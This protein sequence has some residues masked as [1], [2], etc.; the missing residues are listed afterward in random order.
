MTEPI[1]EQ[2]VS[3]TRHI[4]KLLRGQVKAGRIDTEYMLRQFDKIEDL[5]ARI[6]ESTTQEKH[7][8]RFEALYLVGR[9]LGTSL[10]EQ[11]VLDQVMD[12][13]IQ[14]T[15][16]ERGFLMLRDDDGELQPKVARNLDQQTLGSDHFRYSRTIANL[17]LDSGEAIL[18]TNAA[19]DSRFA[20]QVS[21]ISQALR[22]IMAVP[23]WARGNIMGIAYVEN[24]IVAGLFSEDDLNTLEA[25]AGQAAIAIDNAILFSE[26]DEQLAARVEELRQL[27]RVDM[28]LNETL[29]PDEAMLITLESACRIAGAS[30]GHLGIL[31]QGEQ[32]CIIAEH[33]YGQ[34]DHNPNQIL[35]LGGTYPPIWEVIK[36]RQPLSFQ[37]DAK[38]PLTLLAVPVLRKEEVIGLMVLR[39]ETGG[40]STNEQE[41]V[42]RVVTRAAVTIENAR[43][44]AAVQSADKAKSEFVGIVA[45]DL[46]TP[47]TSI[48]GYADLLRMHS[49]NLSKRQYEFANRITDTVKRMEMLVSDL[50]D[51][52]RIESGQFLM[53][54]TRVLVNDVVTAVRDTTMPQI[55]ERKHKYIEEIEPNLPVLWTDYYRL[56]QVL[57]NLISNA[58]KYTPDGG[59]VM[60]RAKREGERVRF[61]V[62]DTGIG[63]SEEGLR[64][65]GTK[66]WRS[67]DEY[68]MGQ[69]GTG[70]GFAIAASLVEQM[71]SRIEIKSKLGKGS[72]FSFS[73]GIAQNHN[74]SQDQAAVR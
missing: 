13:V 9:M 70:L 61:T 71:G 12:A 4:L 16:A 46:K 52:S 8:S 22:S 2:E 62:A 73:V 50:S 51:I 56:M 15:G 53:K 34:T 64:K 29:D 60:L 54:E 33:H 23:L 44:Y 7:S 5:L 36:T 32:P 37:P 59:K 68:T 28:R 35:D 65:L 11:T 69:R 72:A 40:F 27:R 74:E 41:L 10:D 58:Y 1:S 25:L 48:A 3:N 26:T 47:M 24:R 57:T 67:D 63:L 14:L 45:H 21:I 31:V 42:E 30:G 38:H 66:F 18:T 17:V 19:E 55:R 6:G 43:L 49:D 20:G 39:H